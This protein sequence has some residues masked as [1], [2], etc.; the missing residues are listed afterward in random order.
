MT[1]AHSCQSGRHPNHQRGL[2][3]YETPACAIEALLQVEELPPLVWEPAAG[4]GAIVSVLRE[5]GHTVI[6]SDVVDYGYELDFVRDFLAIL[7]APQDCQA[8]LT[9]P[10]GKLAGEFVR[11]A[12]ALAPTVVMLLRSAFSEAECRTDIL[13]YG[14]LARIHQFR[15]RLPMMHRDGWTGP[16]ASSA[17]P[18]AWFVWQ[19]GY[20]GKAMWGRI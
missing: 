11:H 12:I 14:G 3:L 2:D 15:K 6:A 5:H 9:N 13:E 18:F 4:R 10:P 1:L 16:R 17:I 19:R 20:T 8:I 7:T